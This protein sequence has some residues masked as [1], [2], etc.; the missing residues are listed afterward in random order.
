MIIDLE[1]LRITLGGVEVAKWLSGIP[2]IRNQMGAR[3]SL[4]VAQGVYITSMSNPVYITLRNDEAPIPVLSEDATVELT[5]GRDYLSGYSSVV[6][7]INGALAKLN[8]DLNG[9]VNRA[10]NVLI[11][12]ERRSVE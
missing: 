5:V 7:L 4:T 9:I 12:V 3:G 8:S 2:P 11:E 10:T 6:E 1:R